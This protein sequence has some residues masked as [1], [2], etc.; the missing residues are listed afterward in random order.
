MYDTRTKVLWKVLSYFRTPE[1]DTKVLP[2][3][4]TK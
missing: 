3:F 4:R 1:I 2:Y